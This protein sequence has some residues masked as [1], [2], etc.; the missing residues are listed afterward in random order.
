[1]SDG[2]PG[3]VSKA[4]EILEGGSG[5]EDIEDFRALLCTDCA[6]YHHGEEENEECGSFLLLKA[7]LERGAFDLERALREL[8]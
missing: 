4:R 8:G 5:L 1:M 6:F 7:L 2:F 3:F